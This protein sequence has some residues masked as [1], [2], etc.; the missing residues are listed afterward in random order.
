MNPREKLANAGI[1]LPTPVQ[2]VANYVPALQF[3]SSLAISGQ[4]PIVDGRVAFPGRLGDD[5]SGEEAQR[6][7]RQCAINILAV[8]DSWCSGDWARVARC[9]RLGGF[10]QVK[11]TFFELPLAMNGASDLLVTAMGDYGRHV[12]TTVGVSTLPMN[13]VAEVEALFE[14]RS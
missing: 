8:V 14:L 3:G 4:L 7:A 12:R 6:A 9:V 1:Q 5:V 2:P 13:A 10:F 11:D